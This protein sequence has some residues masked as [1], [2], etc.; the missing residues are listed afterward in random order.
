MLLSKQTIIISYHG[1]YQSTVMR[2]RWE[3]RA[4]DLQ[5]TQ[6]SNCSLSVHEN[7]AVDKRSITSRYPATNPTTVKASTTCPGSL[8]R[9][10]WSSHPECEAQTNSVHR[11]EAFNILLDAANQPLQEVLTRCP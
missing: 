1:N 9:H 4:A 7:T 11:Y 10:K 5:A 2:T 8:S 6:L 3:F